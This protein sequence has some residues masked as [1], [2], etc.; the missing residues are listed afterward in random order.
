[1]LSTVLFKKIEI[2]C[3]GSFKRR[4]NHLHPPP[5]TVLCELQTVVVASN[6]PIYCPNLWLGSAILGEDH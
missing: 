4:K 5:P 6:S 3:K 2:L 1:M